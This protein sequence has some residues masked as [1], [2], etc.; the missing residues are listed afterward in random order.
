MAPPNRADR[1]CILAGRE[2]GYEEGEH[3]STKF[4]PN[5][6]WCGM[7]VNYIAGHAGVDIP[8]CTWTPAGVKGFKDRGQWH[9]GSGGI[10]RGDIVFFQFDRDPTPEHVGIVTERYGNGSIGTVEGN[11]NPA[12]GANGYG[13]F[14]KRRKAGVILGYG[15]PKFA[16][17][18]VVHLEA[19]KPGSKDTDP[20]AL[21]QV[22][23]NEANQEHL[24]AD[25][26]FGPLTL[27]AYSRW[28]H[29][30]GYSG[31]D[32]CGIPGK[33]SL[34]VLAQRTALFDVG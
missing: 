33:A 30:C 32:A 27:A 14:R 5:G 20:I 2:V 13:V 6:A 18:P 22:A 19:V 4:G 1:L 17:L 11:T 29:T 12:G 24:K 10:R 23:L 16:P 15:R 21:V 25:G 8:D 9:N 28:Q 31:R 7:F 3:N 34:T 26:S